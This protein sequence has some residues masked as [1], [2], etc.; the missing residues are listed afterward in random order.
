[1]LFCAG[2]AGVMATKA[3]TVAAPESNAIIIRIIPV[4]LKS[5]MLNV[6]LHLLEE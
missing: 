5:R 4:L 6:P 1:M 3:R 2:A